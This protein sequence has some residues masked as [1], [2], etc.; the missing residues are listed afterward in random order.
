VTRT[1][2]TLEEFSV[3]HF[4]STFPNNIQLNF[5]QNIPLNSHYLPY[6]FHPKTPSTS[7]PI[8]THIISAIHQNFMKHTLSFPIESPDEKYILISIHLPPSCILYRNPFLKIYYLFS[9]TKYCFSHSRKTPESLAECKQ[10]KKKTFQQQNKNFFNCNKWL[11]FR[12]RCCSILTF[13]SL[14]H[15]F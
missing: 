9:F 11:C 1:S 6:L 14:F 2:L 4:S 3:L 8:I 13:S 15:Q 12:L 10:Q 5:H 7:I